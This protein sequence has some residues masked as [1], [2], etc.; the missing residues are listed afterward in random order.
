MSCFIHRKKEGVAVCKNCGK[1]MCVECSSLVQHS[2]LCPTCYRPTLIKQKNLLLSESKQIG[3]DIVNKIIL[4][5]ILCFTI[6][7]PLFAIIDIKKMK[8]RKNEEIPAQIRTLDKK[9]K[10]IDKALSQ[11]NAK[12]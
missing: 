7:Y 3:S 1:N 8:Y 4:S 12:I 6:F 10:A 11:G 9:I 5:V 2:G